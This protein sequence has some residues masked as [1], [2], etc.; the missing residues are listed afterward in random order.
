[1]N[2]EQKIIELK[3]KIN[4]YDFR[5]KEKEIKEQKR[6]QNQT[7]PTLFPLWIQPRLKT[8][9]P[10][11]GSICLEQLGRREKFHRLSYA[12]KEKN[13]SKGGAGFP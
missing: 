10:L 2:E 6:M 4:H 11:H 8:R 9:D 3:K 13:T 1:L 5:Q 7:E 12:L